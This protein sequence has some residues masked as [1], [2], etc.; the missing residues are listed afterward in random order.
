MLL[1][2]FLI[3]HILFA[4]F[5]SHFCHYLLLNSQN[6]HTKPCY[7]WSLTPLTVSSYLRFHLLFLH[8]RLV[9]LNL[10][11]NKVLYVKLIRFGDTQ[12]LALRH[13]TTQSPTHTYTQTH[14]YIL[15]STIYSR[16]QTHLKLN[17][18]GDLT[19]I[20]FIKSH[21]KSFY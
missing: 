20:N 8:W 3:N 9:W 18:Y 19:D 5:L 7:S 11:F 16:W 10:H 15:M 6:S 4:I 1:N 2:E 14:T 12:I 17:W 21:N 13:T